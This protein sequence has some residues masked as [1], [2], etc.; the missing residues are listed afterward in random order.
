MTE[1]LSASRDIFNNDLPTAKRWAEILKSAIPEGPT[2]DELFTPKKVDPKLQNELN[3]HLFPKEFEDTVNVSKSEDVKE[4]SILDGMDVRYINHMGDDGAIIRSA[5]VS[6][7][8]ANG[9]QIDPEII[10]S[11]SD[12]GLINYLMRE[13]HGSPFEHTAMTFYVKAPIF[14]FREF[15]RHRMASY[16]EMSGRYM[17]LPGDFYIPGPDRDT[18]N[19]G[20]SSKPEMAPADGLTYKRTQESMYQAY[21]IAWIEYQKL[22]KL[23]V[24]NEVA[25][26]VLPVGIYSQMYVTMNLRGVFNFLSLRTQRENAVHISRPQREIEMVAEEIETI[27]ATLFPVAFEAYEKFGRVAP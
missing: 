23:G 5:R 26:M 6:T 20:T 10:R 11:K 21:S 7:I 24:S 8:G 14:V 16:N 12:I 25:R 15:M 19:I 9:E 22:L 2:I 4:F 1:S 13:K 17:E 18:I 27:A 3:N